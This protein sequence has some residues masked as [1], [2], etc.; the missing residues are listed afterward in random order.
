MGAKLLDSASAGEGLLGDDVKVLDLPNHRSHGVG[1]F[2]ALAVEANEVA[3]RGDLQ[4][5]MVSISSD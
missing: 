5:G 2:V 3:L 4:L 1:D